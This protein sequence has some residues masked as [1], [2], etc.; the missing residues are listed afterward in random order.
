MSFLHKITGKTREQAIAEQPQWEEL[1]NKLLAIGGKEI[2]FVYE[3]DLK[4]LVVKGQEFPAEEAK[5]IRKGMQQSRCHENVARLYAQS[6]HQ[7][8]Q[9]VTGWALTKELWI[10][11]SWGLKKGVVQETTLKREAD[12]GFILSPKQSALFCDENADLYIPEG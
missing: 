3:E 12:Y 9:I 8:F 5:Q 1:A 11:H 2:A 6:R 10:Q 7:G 4:S